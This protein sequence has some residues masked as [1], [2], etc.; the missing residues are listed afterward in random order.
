MSNYFMTKESTEKELKETNIIID[1]LNEILIDKKICNLD[2]SVN[3]LV[4]IETN[5]D[6]KD[7]ILNLLLEEQKKHRTLLLMN[8]EIINKKE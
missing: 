8:M 3:D 4:I 2:I 1:K 6:Y 7:K 5:Y